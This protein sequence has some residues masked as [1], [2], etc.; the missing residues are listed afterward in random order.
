M[1]DS[2]AS[3]SQLKKLLMLMED[4]LGIS[5][6]TQDEKD[7]FA[8]AIDLS[9]N[10]KTV[11]SENIREHKLVAKISQAT[12]FR[13]LSSLQEKGYMEKLEKKR[14]VYRLCT[15]PD[16]SLEKQHHTKE[17]EYRPKSVA[18]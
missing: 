4:D 10:Q 13:T 5:N 2:F 8:A 14:G 6:L 17:T 15:S 7:V 3:F 18:N 1:T 9:D 11:L 16:H 12:Y